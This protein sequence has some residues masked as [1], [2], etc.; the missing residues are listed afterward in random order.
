MALEIRNGHIYLYKYKRVD[1]KVKRIYDGKG[2]AALFGAMLHQ[3]AIQ[4]RDEE[5]QAFQQ[6]C[7]DQDRLCQAES[8]RGR[9]ISQI[10]TVALEG[11]GFIRYARNP[12]TRRQMKALPN[13]EAKNGKYDVEQVIRDLIPQINL[14]DANALEKLRQLSISHPT[15]VAWRI[16]REPGRAGRGHVRRARGDRR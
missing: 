12:W 16:L 11:L 2:D 1:G 14:D 3:E 15:E 6:W 7:A 8:D 4:E 9:A 10:Q 13:G 5:R